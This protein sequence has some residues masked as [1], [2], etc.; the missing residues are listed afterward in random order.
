MLQHRFGR[1]YFRIELLN[2]MMIDYVQRSP[3][4]LRLSSHQKDDSKIN[5][6]EKTQSLGLDG[7][8]KE[9]SFQEVLCKIEEEESGARAECARKNVDH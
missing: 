5:M 3:S 9:E 6:A 1:L 2:S 4:L 8:R 7:E